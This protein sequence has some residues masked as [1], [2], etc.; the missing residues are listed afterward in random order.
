MP[1]NVMKLLKP[2][3]HRE[4]NDFDLSHRHVF[5]ANFGELL[6]ATTIECVPGDYIELRASDLLRALPMVTSPFLRAKQHIDVWFTPYN[7]MWSNFEQ[8]ITQKEEPVSSAYKYSSY[9]PHADLFD[10]AQTTTSTANSYKDVVNRDARIGS[11]KLLDLLGY[12]QI[13]TGGVASDYAKVNLFRIAQYNKIWYDEYRQQYYDDG[14]RLLPAGY[15]AAYLFNFDWMSCDT[16]ANANINSDVNYQRIL[17]AMTQMRYRTWKKDLYTG[18]MPSSQFGAVSSIVDFTRVRLTNALGSSGAGQ[19]VS[20]NNV[21]G[22][23]LGSPSSLIVG[24]GVW[25]VQDSVSYNP[26]SFDVLSLRRSEAIQIWRENALRA[27][28]RISDNLRA[29]Y[30]DVAQYHDH[31]STY[32]GSVDAPLNIGDIDSHSQTGTGANEQLGD[33]A[34]K[35]LS[36]LDEKVFKF[37]CKQFGAIMVIMS[38]LP[39][40]EYQSNGID[41]M[42]QLLEAEDF[43]IPEYQNLGLEAVSSL[44]FLNTALTSVKNIGYAPRYYGYKTK[45]DKCFNGFHYGQQFAAWTSPKVDVYSALSASYSALPISTLYVN[46]SLYDGNFGVSVG[47]SDQFLC[48]VYFDVDAVRPMSVVGMPFS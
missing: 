24:S 27:G 16:Q 35:G 30:G 45:L 37:N 6:P 20:T 33:I 12:G 21:S 32:L 31:R 28:N 4:R 29:H 34:G 7:Y 41:R 38:I 5:S 22:L 47:N 9:L 10:L 25:S 42:N 2:S 46:P 44:N 3:P 15:N 40:A 13:N 18:L 1:K 11:A 43:F 39:E 36:S 26:I 17:D 8:F 48:D 14:T 19:V 23:A